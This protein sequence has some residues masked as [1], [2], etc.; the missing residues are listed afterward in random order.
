MFFGEPSSVIEYVKNKK[1]K[2]SF[3]YDEIAFEAHNKV[4]TIA[5]LTDLSLLKDVQDSLVKAYKNGDN[6]QTWKENIV[7]KLKAKG[8]FGDNVE[9]KN[10]K[11]GE[12]KNIKVSNSKLKRIFNNNMRMAYAQSE[13]ENILKS[14]KEYVR[15]VSKLHGNRRKEH[16]ALHGMILPKDDPFWIYN[17]PPC[18]YGCKCRI[19]GVSQNELKLYGWELS[20][21][22]PKDI[23]DKDFFYDKNLGVEK[24]EKLYKERVSEVVKNFIKL[25]A[26]NTAAR[27]LKNTQNFR[28]EQEL[29]VWQKSLDTMVDEV[30]IKENQ[31]YPITFIQVGKMDE[32]TREFLEKLGLKD[33]QNLHFILS[34]NNL[35]HAAPKRKSKYNQALSIE[36]FKQIVKVL[37]EAKELYWD[38]KEQS[39]VYFFDDLKDDKKVNKIIIKANYK[40]KKFGKTNAV[41]TLAKVN[42]DNKKQQVLVKIR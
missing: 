33:L 36:E 21:K 42:K 18:A 27:F 29:Y 6:F 22:T 5:K 11:T 32:K 13:W 3:D 41:I 10:P 20:K 37:N 35:L 12:I 15:W 17:R 8:W 9:V 31:K 2:V 28:K 19:Q 1:A 39:L 30:L 23:A 40:L 25:E 38:S 34:K 26:I 4:F 24:L 7:P 14:N 16:L